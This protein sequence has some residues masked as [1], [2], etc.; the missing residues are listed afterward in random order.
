MSQGIIN[1]ATEWGEIKPGDLVVVQNK[2]L[3][4]ESITRQPGIYRVS[5]ADTERIEEF[6]DDELVTR[7]ELTFERDECS[8]PDATGTTKIQMA[9]TVE[10][11]E[12]QKREWAEDYDTKP[13]DVAAD[14][15]SYVHHDLLAVSRAREDYW[16]NVS[17]SPA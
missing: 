4:T 6:Y 7:V 9:V 2:L 17:V 14:V 15:R 11:T 5:F 1:S 8:E 16:T 3:C 10:M 13:E 12:Q